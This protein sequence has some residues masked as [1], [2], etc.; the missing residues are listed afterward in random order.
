MPTTFSTLITDNECIK[1]IL[2]FYSFDFK[3]MYFIQ[4]LN[5]TVT[6]TCIQTRKAR[7]FNIGNNSAMSWTHL[8]SLGILPFLP[9]CFPCSS[10]MFLPRLVAN[11]S[12]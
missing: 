7:M 4:I 8:F 2:Q 6:I 12:I 10:E 11:F 1:K 3:I 5:E 9:L